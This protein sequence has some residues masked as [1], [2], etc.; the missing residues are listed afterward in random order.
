MMNVPFELAGVVALLAAVIHGGVGEAVVVS[1]LR[2]EALAPSR[3][4]GPKMTMLMIR[5]TWHIATIAF[6]VIGTALAVCAP[7]DPGGA[8]AGVGRIAA[9]SFTGFAGLAM[10]LG[11]AAGGRRFPS[12]LRRHPGPVALALVAALAW[13]GSL[14]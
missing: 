14:A 1:K 6:A 10:G 2:T 7:A 8:C 12:L 9:I 3:F 5:V 4:G 11:L 13:W